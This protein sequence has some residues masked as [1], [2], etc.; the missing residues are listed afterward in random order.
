MKR[1][2][3]LV[4]QILLQVQAKDEEE[5]G[6]KPLEI[7]G[8]DLATVARHVEIMQEAGLV[9]APRDRRFVREPR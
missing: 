5:L 2:M 9:D 1:D 3:D 6:Q 4:R 8:Y 7:D